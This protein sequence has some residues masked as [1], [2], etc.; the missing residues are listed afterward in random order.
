MPSVVSRFLL[1]QLQNLCTHVSSLPL[2]T[3][4]PSSSSFLGNMMPNQNNAIGN[5]LHAHH[6]CSMGGTQASV[7]TPSPDGFLGE[8]K[9]WLTGHQFHDLL[10]SHKKCPRWQISMETA[11]DIV[12][13]PLFLKPVSLGMR[14]TKRA[15]ASR[16]QVHTNHALFPI[17]VW[18]IP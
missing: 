15:M 13:P 8:K 12:W 17:P 7:S 10:Y 3:P 6:I 4:F 14:S 2:P 9:A 18:L 1:T 5:M 16:T 11:T